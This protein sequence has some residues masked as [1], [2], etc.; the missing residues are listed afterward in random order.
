MDEMRYQLDLLKAMNQKLGDAERMYRLICD[1]SNSAFLYFSFRTGHIKMLGMWDKYF[2]FAVNDIKD[3]A[4]L[5][6]AVE[7]KYV[8]QL[9]DTLFI[10]KRRLLSDSVQCC[11]KNNRSWFEFETDVCYDENGEPT[12]KIIRIKDVTKFRIQNDELTYM[13]YYD[14]LTGL[15]N[16]NYFV[17]LLGEYVRRAEEEN[18][19]ISVMF[20][21]MDDFRKINDGMGILIGDELVQQMGEFLN[22]FSEEKVIACHINSDIYCLASYDP[23]G[24]RSVEYIARAIRERVSKGFLLSNGQEL[25]ITV[26]IGVAEYPEAAQNALEL[27]NCAEIV[28]FKAKHSGKNSIQYFDAPIL[29]EFIQNVTLENELKNA[30]YSHNFEMYYQPQYFAGNKRLRGVEALIRWRYKDGKMISPAVFIP[31]AEKNGTIVSIGNWVI[32]ESVRHYAEWKRKYGY[33][34]ILSINISAIQYKREDFVSQVLSILNKYEVAPNEIELEITESVLIDDLSEV[35]DK[36]YLLREYGIKVSLDDFGTGFSSLS[37]LKGLPIDTLKID[38]SFIDNVVEDDS[39]RIITEAMVS[40]VSK[41]GFET[42]AEGVETKEQYD[43]L[44]DIGCD[45]I[46][47]YLLGR[48]GPVSEIDNLLIHLL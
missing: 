3:L 6:D 44:C 34:M 37:Y 42:I 39:S 26:S 25:N 32:E 33:P 10:E 23:K 47:G 30:V 15:Y 1:T 7:D 2:D 45:A 9:R 20:I 40:M 5:Y 35:K 24:N 4:K 48:P 12:D 41:L 43:Y 22:T 13:A 11:M 38:K 21:D 36:L 19:I 8:M 18:A 28:M 16:R 17:R 29:N 31:I 27:I 46:Q 14:S